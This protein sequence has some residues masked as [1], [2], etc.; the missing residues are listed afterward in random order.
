MLY[1]AKRLSFAIL[2]IL[3][4]LCLQGIANDTTDPGA[5]TE[6]AAEAPPVTGGI[7][8][9]I[10]DKE[11]GSFLENVYIVLE[12]VDPEE[13][14]L[15]YAQ[16]LENGS[17][18]IPEVAP[19]IYTLKAILK[20]Y[21][22]FTITDLLVE[23][24]SI[25]RMD[26]SLTYKEPGLEDVYELMDFVVTADTVE[27][28]RFELMD[29]RSAN[30]GQMD[31]LSLED[32]AKFGGSSLA[33]L[34]SR[35][36][37][38]NVVEGQFAVVRGLGDRYNSTLVNGLPMPSVDP[39]RQGLQ[40]DLFPTSIMSSV[41]SEKSFAPNLPANSS[42]AAFNL[43][44][45]SPSEATE[46]WLEYGFTYMGSVDAF[47][48]NP[49]APGF[50]GMLTGD[51]LKSG[52][53][54]PVSETVNQITSGG[55]KLRAGVGTAFS[56]FSAGGP[57]FRIVFAISADSAR[58][59]NDGV[60]QDFFVTSSTYQ[61]NPPGFQ[62]I[63]LY[64]DPGSLFTNEFGGASLL[65]DYSLSEETALLGLLT[66]LEADLTGDGLNVLGFNFLHSRSGV[67]KVVLRSNGVKAGGYSNDYGYGRNISGN[68][69]EVL[70]IDS[71]NGTVSHTNNSY[72]YEDR[73]LYAVQLTGNHEPS[74]LSDFNGKLNWAWTNSRA[75]SDLGNPDSGNAGT[76]ELNYFTNTSGLNYQPYGNAPI[77]APGDL[78]FSRSGD[79]ADNISLP[80]TKETERYIDDQLQ[81]GRID[82]DLEINDGFE[83][84]GGLFTEQSTR[85][86]EQE[87][88]QTF[89]SNWTSAGSQTTQELIEDVFAPGGA[90]T[91][92][93]RFSSFADVEINK[94]ELYFSGNFAI[95]EIELSTGLRG[96]K[97]DA[98][99]IGDGGIIETIPLQAVLD[100]TLAG[101][102]NLTN[103]QLIGF[104]D[105]DIAGGFD[106]RYVLPAL[107]L[108]VEMPFG[109][110]A[111]A[112]FGKTIALPS[113]RE[114]S[115][116]FSRDLGTGDK[117]LGNP[118]LEVSEVS[119]INFRL[120]REFESAYLAVSLF[121]KTIQDPIEQIG[122]L[123][124]GT[125]DAILTFFNNPNEADVRG[126]EFEGQCSLGLL[127][128]HLE[129]FTINGNV[130]LVDA[131]VDYPEE[132]LN[133]YFG[134]LGTNRVSGPF[135]GTDGPPYGNNNLPTE[136]RLFD[137]PEWTVNLDL[138]YDLQ[139]YGLRAS[140]AYYAQSD[141]LTTVGSGSSL[142]VDQYTKA[143][144]QLDFNLSKTFADD[145]FEL[146]FGIDNITDSKRGIRYDEDLIDDSPDRL[147]YRMGR[148][149]AL[150]LKYKY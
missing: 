133:S 18:V 106:E 100:E 88:T 55:Q 127:S 45:R 1:Y 83:V 76:T 70:G 50:K 4:S 26:F 17:F 147:S 104:E 96:V 131:K 113:K 16:S 109:L 121:Q 41:V 40:L 54:V 8:G 74:F 81:G 73:S 11:N 61:I 101:N 52:R 6:S 120:S 138:S 135:V 2:L 134:G 48:S 19:G 32:F 64:G 5:K 111:R 124:R 126:V 37:G 97:V 115:P 150:A 95:G 71:R 137:Q 89:I 44:T 84:T 39:L 21:H 66:G 28:N 63:T 90:V 67:S 105:A 139:A 27:S 143:Y 92:T 132:I 85:V 22:E 34:V 58:N 149:Y 129:N 12:P 14:E 128:K 122:I 43:E 145:R 3:F 78:I 49:N 116:Y 13:Q 60:Q 77:F 80:V 86:V 7:V 20:D 108:K 140:I 114:L 98:A 130:A 51:G 59:Q 87:D 142:T 118:N 24:G 57:E 141:V 102:R 99:A 42:G 68:H 69:L 125:G 72:S 10:L 25:R 103:G 75:S 146:K 38:V 148:T 33:D 65:Y 9:Q 29:L 23:A 119:N 56:P 79:I 15:K 117:I 46:A 91:T 144:H 53:S 31:F 36:A 47:M 123:Y 136:R 30:V 107:N 112:G 110:E 94:R 93:E 82:L 62:G 35:M